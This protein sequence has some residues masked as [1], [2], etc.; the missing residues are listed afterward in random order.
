MAPITDPNLEELKAAYGRKKDLKVKER[1]KMVLGVL[2]GL[3]TYEVAERLRCPQPNVVYW[4]RR[5]AEEGLEG[6]KDRP[7]SG[8]PPKVTRW[9]LKRIRKLVEKK[10]YWT[11]T[12]VMKLV[13][14]K[15]GV[16]YSLMHVTRLLHSWGL[17][18]QRPRKK[19]V[20][21]ASDEEVERFKKGREKR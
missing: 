5:F 11:A 13:C 8:R 19:H 18:K 1:M 3:S 21:A 6:L 17:S 15:T 14:E 16:Q 20:N 4:K 9:K 2:E 12:E 10:Q 7:R